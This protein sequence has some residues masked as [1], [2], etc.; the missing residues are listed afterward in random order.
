MSIGPKG[1]IMIHAPRLT[2]FGLMLAS[3]AGCFSRPARVSPPKVDPA[4]AAAKAISKCDANNDGAISLEE[5][6][7][8]PSIRDGWRG[9]DADKN[10]RVTADEIESRIRAWVNSN[11]G[12]TSVACSVQLDGRPL[13]G[14]DVALEPEEFLDGE[15]KPATG[16]TDEQ[17][18]TFLQISREL[19]GVQCGYYKVKVSKHV[20]GKESIPPAFNEST[21]LGLEVWKTNDWPSSVVQFKLTSR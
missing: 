11:V 14:A 21:K 3:I 2:L 10:G 5:A 9:L 1:S 6:S 18:T 4:A 15:V 7:S 8:A 13:V 12:I 16:R 20:G 19:P 17:G